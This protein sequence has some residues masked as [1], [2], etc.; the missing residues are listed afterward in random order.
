MN[1][2]WMLVLSALTLCSAAFAEVP[3]FAGNLNTNGVGRVKVTVSPGDVLLA[4]PFATCLTAT[5]ANPTISVA[6]LI[7]TNGLPSAANESELDDAAR[8]FVVENGHYKVYYNNA[9]NGWT[10]YGTVGN[11]AAAPTPLESGAEDTF[12]FL[13]GDGFWLRL[14][15][16]AS[17]DV[18]LAGDV[19]QPEQ[20]SLGVAKGLNLIG[21]ILLDD[22]PLSRLSVAN[23][24][25]GK[26]LLGS[27]YIVVASGG[28]TANYYYNGAKFV[29]TGGVSCEDVTVAKGTAIRYYSQ[30]KATGTT[31]ITLTRE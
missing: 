27:D 10:A 26:K 17:R 7:S 5:N 8:L 12:A 1:S 9:T 6:D 21:T 25:K 3:Q 30:G 22:W 13:P 23:A 11:T 15:G 29:T 24:Y 14:P 19:L 4:A 20:E 16:D 28:N 2:R 31:V 18:Y